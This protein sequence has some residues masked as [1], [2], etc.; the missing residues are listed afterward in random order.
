MPGMILLE[1]GN[2]ILEECLRS[3]ICATEKRIP[4]DVR[5]C[6][7]DDVSYRV[8]VDKSNVDLMKLSV[9]I[10]PFQRFKD[11]GGQNS[12]D[13]NYGEFKGAAENGFD[14]TLHIDCTKVKDVDATIR[15][16]SLV[17]SKVTG[18]AF[19]NP[20]S[21]LMEDKKVE[22]FKFDLRADTTIF[23]CPL[24]DRITVIFE[25]NFQIKMDQVIANVM[26]KEFVQ[27]RKNIGR[28][29]PCTWEQNPPAEL[30]E[31]GVT[32]NKGCLGYMSFAI[33][34]SHLEKGKQEAVTAVLQTFRTYLQYH[35]KC[36]KSYFHSK[37]R[38]RVA[39]LIKVLN[40]AKVPDL[41]KEKKTA[42]G[43]TFKRA[44]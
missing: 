39:E 1:P 13:K 14:F 11:K 24:A 33:L 22:K 37:M 2:R 28:A 29:P 41:K 4:M 3:Q 6:D 7:F 36:S 9:S 19:D 25:V 5:L 43:K 10:P 32:Q 27:A 35:I 20:F 42:G 12:L 17:K 38:K 31:F 15:N 8:F 16:L 44:A 30:K 34:K 40:R 21:G 18:G 26:L 23:L